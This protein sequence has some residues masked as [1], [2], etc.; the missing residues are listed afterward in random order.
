MAHMSDE[1]ETRLR[2]AYVFRSTEQII[3]TLGQVR[4]VRNLSQRAL[5]ELVG[6]AQSAV[7]EWESG[8]TG[9]TLDSL[10]RLARVLGYDLALIPRE[11]A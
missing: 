10:F 7:S 3:G 9:I 5:A 8:Q 1:A 11:D 2:H 4:R 6:T